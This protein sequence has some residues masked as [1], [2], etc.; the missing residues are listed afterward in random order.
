MLTTSKKSKMLAALKI[1]RK[2]YLTKS[3]FNEL[4]ESGTRIM[5]NEFLTNVLGF[6]ALEEVRTEYMIK[7]TYADYVIQV[8]GVRHFLVEVKALSIALSDK[9]LRQAVNYGANEGIEWAILT[10]GKQFDLYKIT[11]GKPIEHKIVFSVDLS[12]ADGLK[13]ATEN[14]QFLHRDCVLKKALNA[15]WNKHSA[16]DPS[17]LAGLLYNPSFV[18]LLKRE[19]KKK[20][21]SKFDDDE[22]MAAIAKLIC[23]AINPEHVKVFRSVK[24]KSGK[25]KRMPELKRD[26]GLQ[27]EVASA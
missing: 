23:N 6:T 14:I 11:F 5:I 20:Y 27:A 24:K 3:N 19:L 15:L 1:Y 18:S 7:G 16:L 22:V 12:D 13:T 9:H 2:K 26:E 17:T 8:K 25:V 10:N 21:K 4:D